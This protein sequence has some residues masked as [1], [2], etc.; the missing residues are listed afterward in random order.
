M[1][2]IK[3]LQAQVVFLQ[4]THMVKSET[5]RIRRRW[6]GQVFATCHASN[7]RGVMTLIHKSVPIQVQKVTKD[8][9]G[10]YIVLQCTIFSE[11]INLINVYGPND[12][13]P[14]FFNDLLLLTASLPGYYLIAGDINC[15]LDPS[16]D[17]STGIDKTCNKLIQEFMKDLN[18]SDVWRDLNPAAVSYSCYSGMHQTYSRINYFLISAQLLNKITDCIYHSIVISDHAAVSLSY[19]IT[20]FIKTPPDGAFR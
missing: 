6:Q 20:K 12:D 17:R 2:R 18:L 19:K 16:K 4:E 13:N 15:V 11:K 3:Q 8:P 10:R 9:L 14:K 5:I 7:A 1:D